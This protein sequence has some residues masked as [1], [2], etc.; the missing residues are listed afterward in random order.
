M[1]AMQ[2][3]G[4]GF[5]VVATSGTASAIAKLGV[6]VEEVAKVSTPDASTIPDLVAAGEID[7]IV[8]TPL[9]R[10]AR[11]D[12][13]AIRR[14]A[15]AA[16]VPCI[17]TLSGATAAVQAIAQAWR[18]DPKPLQELHL[19]AGVAAPELHAAAGGPAR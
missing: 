13:Y 6:P 12:G 10:G 19:M 15:I 5:R 1:L 8:N 4:L 11:G 3:H 16:R 17:T 7:L 9:G 14:A 2:F 18:V